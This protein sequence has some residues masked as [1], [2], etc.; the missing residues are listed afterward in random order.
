MLDYLNEERIR[1]QGIFHYPCIKRLIDEQLA[2]SKDHREPL[3][4]LLVFQVWY[5]RYI[6]SAA[7]A[8]ANICG[9]NI[10]A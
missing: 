8:E 1:R 4:T 6:G 5:E 2:K 7:P 10:I 9:G 3:W